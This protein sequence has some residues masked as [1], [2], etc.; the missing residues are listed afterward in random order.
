MSDIRT[1]LQG[2]KTSYLYANDQSYP[3]NLT[4]EVTDTMFAEHQKLIN[5][6][7]KMLEDMVRNALN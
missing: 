1:L 7:T 4:T 3:Y 5:G 2:G 6:L